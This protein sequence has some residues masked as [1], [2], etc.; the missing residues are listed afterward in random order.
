[1]H[2]LVCITEDNFLEVNNFF[3][4]N[5]VILTD[6]M[7]NS[8]VTNL[9]EKLGSFWVAI[10]EDDNIIAILMLERNTF[11]KPY[12]N[13]ARL[14]MVGNLYVD[15]DDSIFF[16]A[17]KSIQSYADKLSI[18]NILYSIQFDDDLTPYINFGFLPNHIDIFAGE[19]VLSYTVY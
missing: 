16:R 19:V 11:Y 2:K 13:T 6:S 1:M 15:D 5:N 10:K 18:K 17:F 14:Y 4:A 8:Y 12:A 7:W 9:K 3:K